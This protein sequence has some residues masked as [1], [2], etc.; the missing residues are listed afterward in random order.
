MLY[1]TLSGLTGDYIAFN[2]L[3][4]LSWQSGCF[5]AIFPGWR[6]GDGIYV[7]WTGTVWHL[8][9]VVEYNPGVCGINKNFEGTADGCAPEGDY[10]WYENYVAVCFADS[11]DNGTASVSRTSP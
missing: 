9:V 5:W 10:A 1:V 3:W 7:L 2:G 8:L 11:G 6:T 4:T